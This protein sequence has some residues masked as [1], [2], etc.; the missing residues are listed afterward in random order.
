MSLDPGSGDRRVEQ[1]VTEY[2][3]RRIQ[4]SPAIQRNITPQACRNMEDNPQVKFQQFLVQAAQGC[5][6][7]A[8]MVLDL[9]DRGSIVI[10]SSSFKV[11]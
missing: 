6:L 8:K 7:Y 10:K 11:E 4:R 2:V 3:R 9:L 5:F 1:D